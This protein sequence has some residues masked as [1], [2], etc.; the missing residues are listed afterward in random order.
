M[1]RRLKKLSEEVLHQNPWNVYKHDTYELPNGEVGNYYYVETPGVGMVVP[2]M[3]DGR[4]LL[5]LQYRYLED[6]Q[7]IEFPAGGL[8]GNEPLEGTKRELLEETGCV[9]ENWAKL[10]E[11]ESCS[12]LLKDRAHVFV[13]DVVEQQ[14]PQLDK[15][16]QIELLY[17]R[18]REI[19]EMIQKNDIWDG[20]SLAAW[21]LARQ[22]FLN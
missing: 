18:P 22:Y 4:V 13:C 9:G 16:E 7:S 15:T 19:D 10:G 14:A 5:V 6:K 11:F 21:A 8:K 2:R 17:R 20:Q 12:G 3:L 1:P